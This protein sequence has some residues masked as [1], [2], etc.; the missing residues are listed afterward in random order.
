MFD[1]TGEVELYEAVA[2]SQSGNSHDVFLYVYCYKKTYSGPVSPTDDNIFDLFYIWY[3]KK[4]ISGCDVIFD[5]LLVLFNCRSFDDRVEYEIPYVNTLYNRAVTRTSSPKNVFN[6]VDYDT[7]KKVVSHEIILNGLK[8]M[9]IPGDCHPIYCPPLVID[10][11]KRDTSRVNVD[12]IIFNFDGR[13][14]IPCL[15]LDEGILDIKN[16]LKYPEKVSCHRIKSFR[17]LFS[18]IYDS[19]RDNCLSV[20]ECCIPYHEKSSDTAVYLIRPAHVP[21]YET[22]IKTLSL[23]NVGIF[24]METSKFGRIVVSGIHLQYVFFFYI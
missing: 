9:R 19:H 14:K 8:D 15:Y 23:D 1:D 21:L 3:M 22:S 20:V 18:V 10:D 16:N 17:S 5:E 4:S 11:V 12:D 2:P 7:V 13:N 6:S 24:L